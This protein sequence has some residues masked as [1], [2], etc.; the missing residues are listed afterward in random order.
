MSRSSGERFGGG[1]RAAV[2][3][4]AALIAVLAIGAAL[5]LYVTALDGAA[6]SPG[7]DGHTADA[8]LDRVERD[9]AD[10]GIVRPNELSRLDARTPAI[11]EVVT[12]RRRWRVGL[13]GV[14]PAADGRIDPRSERV[15]ERSVTVAVAPGEN[16]RGKLRVAVRR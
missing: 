1:D 9:V 7:T 2:E 16:V 5:G 13:A 11:V 10:G 3:P 6:P 15:A 8:V 12:E 14:D 4:L